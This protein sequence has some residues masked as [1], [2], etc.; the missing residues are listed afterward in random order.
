MSNGGTLIYSTTRTSQYFVHFYYM[1]KGRI[2]E[3]RNRSDNKDIL[4]YNIMAVASL[5]EDRSSSSPKCSCN[6][7][8]PESS[9]C[10]L[11]EPQ[12][13]ALIK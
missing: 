13:S 7:K 3:V 8:I 12:R 10:S 9:N 5:L 1:F 6:E 11:K 4:V 2:E